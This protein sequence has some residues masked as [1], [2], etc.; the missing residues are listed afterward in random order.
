MRAHKC[1]SDAALMYDSGLEPASSL[2]ARYLARTTGPGNDGV[3]TTADLASLMRP[4]ELPQRRYQPRAHVDHAQ[5]PIA[6]AAIPTLDLENAMFAAT[7]RNIPQCKVFGFVSGAAMAVPGTTSGEPTMAKPNVHTA[8]RDDLVEAGVRAELADEILKLRR[9]GKIGLE[10]LDEVPGVGPA[11]LEQLRKSLD[12]SDQPK[13]GDDRGERSVKDVTDKVTEVGKRAVEQTAEVTRELTDRT[14]DMVQQ[15]LQVVQGTADAVRELPRKV[16]LKSTEGTAEI[17]RTLLGLT[18]E[19]TRQNLDMMWALTA[20][21]DW[22]KAVKAVDWDRVIQLQSE[23]LRASLDRSAQLTQRYLEVTQTVMTATASAARQ[24]A[25]KAACPSLT[26]WLSTRRPAGR[27]CRPLRSS[28]PGT[29]ASLPK[30]WRD[31]RSLLLD[32]R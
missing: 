22:N 31:H 20:A 24:Q 15:G 6:A 8:S 28:V 12:F 32:R 1:H 18:H 16:A 23:F 14:G 9:K 2:S 26:P 27:S 17:G 5:R 4:P 3:T 25:R 11:T 21:V 13:N 10:A 19:Q 7:E 30:A 29:I